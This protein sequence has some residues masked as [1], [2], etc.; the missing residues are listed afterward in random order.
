MTVW[1]NGSNTMPTM[2]SPY[3]YSADYDGFHRG[4]DF[5]DFDYNCAHEDGE[6]IF[7]GWTDFGD[8]GGGIEVAIQ[9]GSY[10]SRMLHNNEALVSRGQK[11]SEGQPV[12]V[13]GTTAYGAFGQVGKHCHDEIRIGGR[14]G[15]VTDPVPFLA[16]RV[17]TTAAG[18]NSRPYSSSTQIQGEDMLVMNRTADNTLAL[19]DPWHWQEV[20]YGP[21]AEQWVKDLCG[22]WNTSLQAMP[23]SA[24]AWDLRSNKNPALKNPLFVIDPKA[25]ILQPITE[26]AQA[27]LN[28]DSAK[29]LTA[30]AALDAQSDQY[31]AQV[32]E[33]L[34]RGLSGTLV[35]TPAR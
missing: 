8:G 33:T 3:G 7:A 22:A 20:Y 34:K 15:L 24:T 32:L 26:A 6:V 1:A 13:Q 31:Q 21:G 17:G 27:P 12:G 30:I 4:A 11:V 18:G 2:T 28:N 14:N 16:N 19:Y 10:V 5:I 25:G 9:Y 23:Y 29:I 35:L